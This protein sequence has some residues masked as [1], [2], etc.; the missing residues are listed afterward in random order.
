MSDEY[1]SVTPTYDQ[2]VTSM[3]PVTSATGMVFGFVVKNTTGLLL[4]PKFPIT[5]DIYDD[6]AG[7]RIATG[8]TITTDN[9]TLPTTYTKKTGVLRLEF[10]DREGRSATNTLA[11]QSGPIA[12]ASFSPLS[13]A[14]MKDS[15]TLV[16]LRLRD[17]L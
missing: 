7:S 3:M 2:K 12:R 6:V 9:Y 15:N 16:S 4:A 11:I 1:L 13:S 8:I 5:L 10:R 14:L 17:A